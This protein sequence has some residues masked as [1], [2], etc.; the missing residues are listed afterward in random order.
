MIGSAVS[1]QLTRVPDTHRQT[2][3]VTLRQTRVGE[4]RAEACAAWPPASTNR[5]VA[6][7]AL[8]RDRQTDRQTPV[9]CFTLL[10]NVHVHLENVH[11]RS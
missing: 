6:A 4:R 5:R 8:V 2:T 11:L 7:V 9:R 10:E 3:L 1:A